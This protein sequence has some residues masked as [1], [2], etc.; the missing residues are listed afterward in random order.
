[1]QQQQ[2]QKQKQKQIH[3]HT[4]SFRPKRIPVEDKCLEPEIDLVRWLI[5][6]LDYNLSNAIQE[7][8][9]L[10]NYYNIHIHCE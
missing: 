4:I 1:M 7:Y 10:F 6:I 9:F 8:G 5:Q 2:Q 3:T